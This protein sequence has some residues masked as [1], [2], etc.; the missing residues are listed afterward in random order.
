MPVLA[1][2]SVAQASSPSVLKEVLDPHCSLAIWSR[3]NFPDL[4][5]MLEDDVCNV[6]IASTA[7]RF[8]ADLRSALSASGYAKSDEREMLVEDASHLAE[9][10]SDILGL[11]QVEVRLE[12]VTTN[13]CRKW[14][15]DFVR[16]RLISTYVGSGTQWLD[17]EASRQVKEGHDPEGFGVMAAGDVG[18]FN[19]KHGTSEPAI[20]RSPPIAGTGEKRLLFV[21][22]PGDS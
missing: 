20:H 13:S 4:S 21:L 5:A 16:A 15:A 14:H 22:N 19:G 11:D 12:V 7:A 6:R 3:P 10:Y 8:T 1:D 9:L 18:I 17:A 2:T